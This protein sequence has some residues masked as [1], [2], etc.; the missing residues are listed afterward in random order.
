MANFII[1]DDHPIV[2]QGVSSILKQHGHNVSGTFTNSTEGFSSLLKL[3][4]DVIITDLS[5]PDYDGFEII[6]I[7]NSLNYNIKI[8]VLTASNNHDD[9]NRC[10]RLGVN[11]YIL[12][13]QLTSELLLAVISVLSGINYYPN[14]DAA[15]PPLQIG[16]PLIKPVKLTPQETCIL[17]KLATGKRNKEIANEMQL[18]PKTVS[19]Y[20]VKICKKL[21]S[22]NLIS[23]LELAR[24][25]N[26]IT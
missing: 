9:I 25:I 17:N 3:Q 24:A 7:L 13:S 15:A 21:G 16:T 2:L 20:K 4:P 19:T 14:Q 11:G 8:I 26:L 12:K 23:A 18:S 1:I 6:K 10:A 5:M 22:T